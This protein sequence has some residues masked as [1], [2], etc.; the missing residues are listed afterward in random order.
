MPTQ[1]Q[2]RDQTIAQTSSLGHSLAHTDGRQPHFT[3]GGGFPRRASDYTI[4]SRQMQCNRQ[5]YGD[6]HE[7]YM[8][9]KKLCR[10]SFSAAGTMNST[11]TDASKPEKVP[12]IHEGDSDSSD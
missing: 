3:P 4:N 9:N 7:T 6:A 8:K 12:E 1:Q 2:S 10:E 5:G 11:R